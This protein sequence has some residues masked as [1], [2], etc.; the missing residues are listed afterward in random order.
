[1]FGK[2]E[3]WARER[4][5]SSKS[6]FEKL[7]EYKKSPYVRIKDKSIIYPI[8]KSLFQEMK[9]D[10]GYG[11]RT[12]Q[13]YFFE[14]LAQGIYGGM[15]KKRDYKKTTDSKEIITSEPDLINKKR[16]LLRE[17]KSVSPNNDLKL[18]DT[19]MAKYILLQTNNYLKNK[20]EIKFDVF[21]HGIKNIQKDY[22]NKSLEEMVKDLASSIKYAISIPFSLIFEIY[23]QE[24]NLLTYRYDGD[25]Y[26]KLS[27]L[28]SKGLN[29]LIQNPEELIENYELNSKDF[30]IIRRRFP[31]TAKINNFPINAFPYLEIVDKEY[32]KFPAILKE[33]IDKNKALSERLHIHTKGLLGK[34][35]YEYTNEEWGIFNPKFTQ[36]DEDVPF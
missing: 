22:I 23:T 4:A 36:K 32:K 14:L 2:G 6:S 34:L 35:N 29:K 9:K 18:R 26:D 13:G 3:L 7:N 28:T 25:F 15:I 8:Q 1:V 27:S 11:I 17:I 10:N 21:R 33:K 5:K 19:Q 31:K 30:E 16:S 24:E 20:P 12:K